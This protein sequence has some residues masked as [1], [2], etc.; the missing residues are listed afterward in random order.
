MARNGSVVIKG[1]PGRPSIPREQKRVGYSL[2]LK[3]E[4]LA[5]IEAEALAHG[6]RTQVFLR[7]YVETWALALLSKQRAAGGPGA[8]GVPAVVVETPPAVTGEETE[9]AV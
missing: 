3:A 6:T 7:D 1:Q 4:V 8:A 5:A 9:M 2:Y